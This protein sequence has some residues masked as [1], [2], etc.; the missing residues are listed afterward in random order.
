[1]RRYSGSIRGPWLVGLLVVSMVLPEAIAEPGKAGKRGGRG[2]R[3]PRMSA[4]RRPSVA[5]R[6]KSNAARSPRASN[7]NAMTAANRRVVNGNTR[8][9]A[10]ATAGNAK[11]GVRATGSTGLAAGSSTSRPNA[12]SYGSGSNARHYTAN[13]YGHGSRNRSSGRHYGRSQGNDR[14][15][16]ARLRSVHSGLARLDRDYQGHRVN[17]MQSISMAIRMLSHRSSSLRTGGNGN[18]NGNVGN[19]RLVA[20]NRNAAGARNGN[21]ANGAGQ[22]QR[23][24]QAQSDARMSQALRTTQGIHMQMASNASASNGHLAARTHTNRAI[25]ELQ[26]ALA[27]R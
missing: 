5:P 24:T 23:M 7:N 11:N 25:H 3:T 20:N 13:G 22:G 14:S 21:R 1:M 9:N 18:G 15:L 10:H 4:P 26:T 27:V 17:S 2:G 19:N 8:T 6:S 16:V 12:Y